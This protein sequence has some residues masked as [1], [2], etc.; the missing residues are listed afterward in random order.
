MVY[1]PGRPNSGGPALKFKFRESSTAICL[2]DSSGGKRSIRLGMLS[3]DG[4]IINVGKVTVPPN[5]PI[6]Q[7]NELVEVL[8]LYKYEDG[9]LF[10]PVMLGIRDDQNRQDCTLVQ[11]KRIK[12]KT[13]AKTDDED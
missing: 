12:K 8:Y 5:Q 6:P 7:P 1:M 2:G 3:S 4:S 11:V 13:E 10:Q 9:A